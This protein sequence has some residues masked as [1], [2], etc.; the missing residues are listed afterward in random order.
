MGN[1]PDLMVMGGG[2]KIKNIDYYYNMI[3]NGEKLENVIRKLKKN[4]KV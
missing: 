2:Q 4:Y 1:I 3:D